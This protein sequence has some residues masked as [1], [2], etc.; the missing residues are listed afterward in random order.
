MTNLEIQQKIQ[1]TAAVK[2]E[3]IAIK[4][5]QTEP[6]DVPAYEG[7]A[8]PGMCCQI[9]EALEGGK[10]FHT[11]VKAHFCTG[12]A[13]ATGLIP[14]PTP[15]QAL[16]IIKY[17]LNLTN[18]YR[19]LETA[20]TYYRKKERLIPPVGQKNTVTQIGPFKDIADPDVVLIFCTPGAADLIS[21]AYTFSTGKPITGFGG[22]GG[23]PFLIQYP[24]T[25]GN[26]SF[27]YSDVAWRK[28]VGLAEE[29][30]TLS[31][32][33]RCLEPI[34][35]VIEEVAGRYRKYGEPPEE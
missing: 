7:N 12:G 10:T 21:R 4:P 35:D 32:P 24:Y 25:T 13:L 6:H 8:F 1:S 26:P 3:F 14:T 31:F 19:D 5:L 20:E 22:N 33:Y 18:D 11:T 15:E 16:G 30:L 23:C 17:H 29:E 27:S 9:G 2:K 28:Y 34:V